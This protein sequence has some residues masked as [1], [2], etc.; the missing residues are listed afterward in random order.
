MD[1][2]PKKWC[3]VMPK[4][5][6]DREKCVRAKVLSG[7]VTDP[8]GKWLGSLASKMIHVKESRAQV[9]KSGSLSWQICSKKKL[10]VWKHPHASLALLHP[11]AFTFL[12]FRLGGHSCRGSSLV[13]QV[14]SCS[15]VAL[16]LRHLERH[17]FLP[18]KQK[19]LALKDGERW[20]QM[21]VCSI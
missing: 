3:Q 9:D 13:A 17:E 6:F 8:Q 19:V 4:G 1:R 7:K 20:K 10:N 2:G 5:R 15:D 16:K 14:W 18:L 11:F 12:G 21:K